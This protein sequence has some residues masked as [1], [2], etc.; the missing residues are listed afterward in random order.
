M[1][2]IGRSAELQK[3][4]NQVRT[5]NFSFSLI[6]GRRRVGKSEL[7]HQ[8]L[9]TTEVKSIY[10]ECKQVAEA[11][12]AKSLGEIVSECLGLPQLGYTDMESLLK[13]LFR[14]AENE[15]LVLVLDEYPYLRQSVKGM[16]SILQSLIDTYRTE[17]KLKIIILGSYVE[18]MK[19]LIEHSNPLYGRVDLVIHL[20]PMD[21]YESSL[22]YP[23]F[24]S[25][26]KVRIYSVFGGIPYYNQLVD[27]TKSV[28]ENIM[29]L[30]A[31][32]QARFENEVTG[33]LNAEIKKIMNANEVFEA[34]AKGYTKYSDILSQ[35]H[36]S[37]GPTLI[38]VLEKLIS[39]EIV[40]KTVPINAGDNKKRAGYEIADNLSLFYYRYIFK[41]S[42]Q[43][44]IMDPD[45][46]YT[47]YIENDFETQYVPLRFE[48]IC[49][50]Y[51]IRENRAGR[52][53]PVIE[54]I[55]KYYFDNPKEHKNG[56]F[57]IVTEDEN[58]FVFYE[59]KFRKMPV[60][61]SM[62]QQEIS[63]V[64]ETGLNCYKYVFF[65]RNGLEA[66]CKNVEEISLETLYK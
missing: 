10:F 18:I 33:Y 60:T 37:S 62:V 61:E 59:V 45:V 52:I 40:E 35:S 65:T 58:G 56:E 55:G 7:V 16:D 49:K 39:M 44:K 43:M 23:G 5:N 31:S 46:F 14:Y 36:V 28:K 32:P 38:D 24:S 25:E 41:Y 15:N 17:S 12:N 11:N 50:Q 48:K 51:L 21:Y 13:Y 22:F 30:I 27:D 47:R 26:D 8:L 4:Q 29:E 64:E 2:F 54:K 6:Y 9:K 34:L 63:Q 19:S 66:N 42:S 1:E 57:D 20:K 3:L 53:E